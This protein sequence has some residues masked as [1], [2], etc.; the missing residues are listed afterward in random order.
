[1]HLF[2]IL[3]VIKP[4]V[5]LKFKMVQYYMYFIFKMSYNIKKRCVPLQTHEWIIFQ[6]LCCGNV[7]DMGKS[8]FRVFAWVLIYFNFNIIEQNFTK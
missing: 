3:Y 2:E 5:N 4:N 7:T 6:C 1:M 8:Y